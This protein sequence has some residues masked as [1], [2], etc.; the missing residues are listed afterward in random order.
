MAKE[1]KRLCD[2]EER[3]NGV[4]GHHKYKKIEG[5]HRL[6]K[7]VYHLQDKADVKMVGIKKESSN[8]RKGNRNV[9][10]SMYDIRYYPE[11]GVGKAAVRR[12]PCAC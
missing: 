6:K 2:E 9:I 3:Y 1:C 7:R 10:S 11:L 12:I 4:T 8:F 5:I